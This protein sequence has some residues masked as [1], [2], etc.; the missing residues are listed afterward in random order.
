[1]SITASSDPSL[2]DGLSRLHSVLSQALD[3]ADQLERGQAH[4]PL[5]D[6]LAAMAPD[7]EQRP[8]A[9]LLLALDEASR[10]AV[11]NWLCQGAGPV[12]LR[13]TGQHKPELPGREDRTLPLAGASGLYPNATPAFC[14]VALQDVLLLVPRSPGEL[15]RDPPLLSRLLVQ[16]NVLLVAGPAGQE[17]D[18]ATAALLQELDAAVP[19]TWA[20]LCGLPTHTSSVPHGWPALLRGPCALTHLDP[21]V[22]L[23]LP[24]VLREGDA[25]IGCQRAQRL[26]T[27]VTLVGNL[28][29]RDVR[30]QE[31]RRKNLQRR[32]ADLM[33]RLKDQPARG[34]ADAIRRDLDEGLGRLEAELGERLRVR[35]LPASPGVN[36]INNYLE[37]LSAADLAEES[38]GHTTQTG[39]RADFL[40]DAARLVRN[41]VHNDL[42]TDLDDLHQRLQAAIQAISARLAGITDRR[43]RLELPALDEKTAGEL[44]EKMIHLD[45]QYRSEAPRQGWLDRLMEVRRPV[46]IAGMTL[47]MFGAAFGIA[48]HLS[49]LLAPLLLL[50]FLGSLGWAWYRTPQERRERR[51]RE[52]SRLR[53]A[54]GTELKRLYERALREWQRRLTG[55]LRQVRHELC[56]QAEEHLRTWSQERSR[57]NEREQKDIQ[58]KQKLLDQ[59]LRDLAAL[60]QQVQRVRQATAEAK[61]ALERAADAALQRW[62]TAGAT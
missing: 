50:L 59:R 30:Q 62:R 2:R 41:I 7:R 44:L 39:V 51:E 18:P 24:P 35:G 17:V 60:Q 47:S 15:L 33:T 9:L 37:D 32:A 55:H 54:L 27:A 3:L 10:T 29:D 19:A 57:A 28:L 6:H 13:A 34:A 53:E 58:E 22:P 20:V 26:E 5:R 48:G 56:R 4:T 40:K 1:M 23:P 8:L 45:F 61:Q 25:L 14:S 52:L 12:N 36:R 16:A 49:L 11:L 31:S 42:K 46:V 43:E 38:A 21:A